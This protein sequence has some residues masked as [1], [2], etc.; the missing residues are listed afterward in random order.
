MRMTSLVAIFQATLLYIIFGSADLDC[1]VS[2]EEVV[3]GDHRI[4]LVREEHRHGRTY[5]WWRWSGDLVLF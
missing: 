3:E 2:L 1:S 4:L 5:W